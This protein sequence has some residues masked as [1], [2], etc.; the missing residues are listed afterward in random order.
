MNNPKLEE[1][2]NRLFLLWNAFNGLLQNGK[3]LI[4]DCSFLVFLPTVGSSFS[5]REMPTL[6]DKKPLISYPYKPVL[7]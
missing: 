2:K 4:D 7:L 1:E 6:E 3:L 5:E